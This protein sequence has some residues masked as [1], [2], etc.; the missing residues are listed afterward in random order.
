MIRLAAAAGAMVL[1]LAL[2]APAMAADLALVIG[3]S[4]YTRAPDAVSARA[5]AQA[6]SDALEQGGYRVIEGINLNRGEMRRQISEFAGRVDQ[7]DRVVVFYSGHALRA[8]GRS[9]LAPV[10]QG[11]GSLV[12]VMM[13]GVPLELVLE[14][15]ARGGGQSV[16]FIDGA[17][18]DGFTPRPFA[19][20]GLAHID[21]PEGVLVVSA[22]PPGR[23]IARRTSGQ[24]E[25]GRDVVREFLAPGTTVSQG[26]RGIGSPAWV[27]GDT[28]T[29]LA[30]V[31]SGRTGTGAPSP[32]T[33]EDRLNLTRSER[34]QI[35]EIL[36]RR[37]YNTR[38]TEGIFGSGTRSAIRNWQQ[39]NNY[40][41]TGYLTEEQVAAINRQGRQADT[42]TGTTPPAGPTPAEIEDRLSLTNAERVR[43]QESLNAL[44]Y[45]TRGTGGVFGPGTRTAIRNWQ[46][47]NDLEETGYLTQEQVA[48]INRQAGQARTGATPAQVEDRLNLTGA[49][50]SQIQEDLTRLGYDTR[51]TDGVFG[52]GTR[53]AIRNW[54][55]AQ[56][57]E[58]TGYL[59]QE[60]LE[61]LAQQARQ[62]AGVAPQDPASAE[63][64]LN[65]ARTD[66]L[67]IE[68]RLAYLGFPPGPEDGFFDSQTRR[69]IENYQAS[70]GLPATGYLD[71][72]TVRSL[73]DETQGVRTGIVTGAQVLMDIL[74]G[75]TG[76]QQ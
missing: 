32:A 36:T 70:R 76:Q 9:Y 51:G 16:V 53:T 8:A 64:Q 46:R 12:E 5:D 47:A 24:S 55:R 31:P 29:S 7:A 59:S 56:N 66:R 61:V 41:A 73:V 69:A 57:F 13:D 27:A 50:R 37:G 72:Q 19:E 75:I 28:E 71:R 43:L 2:T 22:A 1:S 23:A 25:F 60:Q 67:S 20:P 10:D 54:Q 35:Q 40:E 44:G 30:L 48:A 52:P 14:L 17:Q 68:Q 3:N 58:E 45:D 6:V 39:A 21:P 34:S 15:A 62:Q 4:N 63:A 49:E 11:N 74:Q 65:L 33:I 38:G 18:L 26:V 42:G